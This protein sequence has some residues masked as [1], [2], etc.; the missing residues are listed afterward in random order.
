MGNRGTPTARYLRDLARRLRRRAT[1][2]LPNPARPHHPPPVGIAAVAELLGGPGGRWHCFGLWRAPPPAR[3]P[4]PASVTIVQPKLRRSA[5]STPPRK[6]GCH[7][8]RCTLSACM[9]GATECR[10]SRRRPIP[11]V[12]KASCRVLRFIMEVPERAECENAEQQLRRSGPLNLRRSSWLLFLRRLRP[13]ASLFRPRQS[14]GPRSIKPHSS[15]WHG[16]PRGYSL[17][18]E[19]VRHENPGRVVADWITPPCA[20]PLVSR[21]SASP[22][23][24]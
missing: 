6:E 22:S 7:T 8:T 19:A 16:M 20:L 12:I 9:R 3:R 10:V 21:Y 24:C 4:A 11:L 2:Q 18:F 13:T 23:G 17:G 15:C 14:A 5:G 1:P